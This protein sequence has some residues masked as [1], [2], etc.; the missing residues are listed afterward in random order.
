[1][2]F[3]HVLLRKLMLVLILLGLYNKQ[4]NKLFAVDIFHW[5]NAAE[6]AE[7]VKKEKRANR[8]TRKSRNQLKVV[9]E[10]IMQLMTL[11]KALAPE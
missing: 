11:K 7:K 4:A 6:R 10:E 9:C 3:F 2:M 5:K 8:K 1:M